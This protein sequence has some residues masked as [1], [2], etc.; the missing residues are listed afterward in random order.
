MTNNP[1]KLIGLKGYG[2]ELVDRVRIAA[3]ETEEN[4]GYLETTRTK[5]GHLL[6]H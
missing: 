2:L 1:M 3:P 4:A 5:M 6:S